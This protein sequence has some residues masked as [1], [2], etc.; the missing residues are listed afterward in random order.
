MHALGLF[1]RP[2]T[3]PSG[4]EFWLMVPLLVSVA[5]VYKTIRTKNLNRLPREIALLVA[6]MCGGLVALGVVLWSI[7]EYWH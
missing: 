2:M 5:I 6:Y 1:Y 7:S 3:L 4:A